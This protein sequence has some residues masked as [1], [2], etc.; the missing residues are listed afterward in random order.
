MLGPAGLPREIVTRL[1]GD[2]QKILARKD[3]NERY[4]SMGVELAPTGPEEM[5][6]FVRQQLDS[7]GRKIREAGIQPE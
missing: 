5:A 1:A 2:V 6:T 7:W 3:I 4:A